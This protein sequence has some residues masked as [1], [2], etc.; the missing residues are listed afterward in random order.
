MRLT[1]RTLLAYLDDTLEPEEA[2]LIGQKVAESPVALELIERIR[3]VTR[4]RSLAPPPA[5]GSESHL[6]P[7]TVAEYLDSALPPEELAQVEQKCLEDD[8]H[9]AEVA[10]CHQ[11]LTLILSE[12]ARVPAPAR[13]RMYR[14]N[15]GKE[16]IPYRRPPLTFPAPD[17]EIFEH[18][19]PKNRSNRYRIAWIVAAILTVGLITA[20]VLS[21]PEEQPQRSAWAGYQPAPIP[22]DPTPKAPGPIPNTETEKPIKKEP[23][24][25]GPMPVPQSTEPAVNPGAELPPKKPLVRL[26]IEAPSIERFEAG[27]LADPID[28]LIAH[29]ANKEL[30]LPVK[31]K[32]PVFTADDLM[33]LPGFRP[34]VKLDSG[35]RL[36][37]WGNLLE[38]L[39]LPALECQITL[40]RPA[41]GLMADLTF[42]RGRVLIVNE[43]IEGPAR[44]RLRYHGEVWDIELQEN[45]EV[46]ADG[47]FSLEPGTR[48]VPGEGSTNPPLRQLF[49][50]VTKGKATVMIDNRDPI[51][52]Q[53]PP[54]QAVVGWDN[55]G[56]LKSPVKIAEPL[57]QW[58]R[59]IPTK[60]PATELKAVLET[61][62][63]RLLSGTTTAEIA[64]TELAQQDD[65]PFWQIYAA[66]GLQSLGAIGRVVDALDDL[67][68]PAMRAAAIPA[69]RHWVAR[70]QKN[71]QLLHGL[72]RKDKGYL[73]RQADVAV[74]LMYT[75]TEADSYERKTYEFLFEQLEDPKL[76]IRELA[77]WHLAQLDP[78]GARSSMYNPAA[79]QQR[80]SALRRWKQRL[81]DGKLP[82]KPP[83]VNVPP[84]GKSS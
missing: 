82:P 45:A 35:V 83:K 43:R 26:P 17:A 72:L 59:D 2:K 61:L 66:Y 56:R 5:L 48:F 84:A 29:Q 73:S 4:R 42:D 77:Y 19:V 24:I 67:T 7:N 22:I 12:P 3:K 39:A 34:A 55:K 53:A 16:S 79:D 70:D 50:G 27:A 60:S 62:R 11:I 52:L 30:W 21:W 57:P 14:L 80:E 71:S 31:A 51:E 20:L 68:K 10:A 8:V 81:T 36:Q 63:D 15:R 49:V 38:F 44:V 58:T 54:G 76:A 9:L 28:L 46:I 25:V 65:K 78:D 64:L 33:A 32:S 47:L 74:Q 37:L 40:H 69:L 75:L 13:Q 18:N 1:L 23:E 41:P 6:D